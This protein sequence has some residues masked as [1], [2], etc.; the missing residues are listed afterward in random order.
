MNILLFPGQGSQSVGMGQFLFENYSSVRELFEQASDTLDLNFQKLCFEGPEE[1][2]QKT[3]N[4]QP[5]ILLVSTACFRVLKSETDFDWYTSAG[6]SLGEYSAFVA[7]DSIEFTTALK[8]VRQRA[9]FMQEA[10]A[11]GEGAMAAILGLEDVDVLKICQKVREETGK[12]LEPANYNCPGQIVVSGHKQAIDFL[13]ANFQSKWV[14]QKVKKLKLIPLKVS[15]P[16]HCSLMKPA[17]DRMRTLLEKT[18]LR[19]PKRPV[20]QNYT[21]NLETEIESLRESLIRQISSP[22]LWEESMIKIDESLDSGS[23]NFLELGPGKVLQKISQKS[24]E[25]PMSSR[26]FSFFSSSN[27]EEF[28]ILLKEMAK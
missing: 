3:E 4:T 13:K 1:E 15:A 12:V 14:N 6:H 2:L 11:M 26:E 5:A 28:Q 17:E 25:R 18:E 19:Q 10:V 22:V 21:A 24:L 23:A 7:N 20:L 9:Q 16:F 8:L 27:Q